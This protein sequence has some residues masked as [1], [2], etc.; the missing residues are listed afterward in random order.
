MNNTAIQVEGLSKKYY[1]GG[2]QLPYQTIRERLT[3]AITALTKPLANKKN[4]LPFWA[5][6]D[7][8][9]D[10]NY[11]ETVG[12][13]GRNGAGKST[14]LKLL[15]RITRPTTGRAK[16]YG[17]VGSLLEVGTGF[18]NE[19]TGRE[20]VYLNGAILGMKK[21]EIE[22]KFDE[23]VNFAEIE[24]FLDTP[25]KHY[26]SGMYMRLAFAVAAHLDPEILLVDEVLAV[27]DAS[28]QKKCLGK[29]KDVS[30]G[31]RT[32]LFVSH[33]HQAVRRLCEKSIWLENGYL[34][35]IGA[36]NEVLDAY[37][38]T[39]NTGV[40]AEDDTPDRLT[41]DPTNP[42][43]FLRLA[44][45]DSTGTPT[46]LLYAEE[47]YFIEIEYEFT[48]A[49][50]NVR[51]AALFRT[52]QDIDAFLT[53]DCDVSLVKGQKR[54][55]GRYLTRCEIPAHLLSQGRYRI[56]VWG[57]VT[58]VRQLRRRDDALIVDVQYT[59]GWIMQEN[60]TTAVNPL[61]VWDTKHLDG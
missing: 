9:F 25:V 36:T 44:V 24:K 48:Y 10:I 21:T 17:R 54:S 38:H 29:M 32:V 49:I 55:P 56:T 20:N 23:I 14:L 27:G 26:S 8:S 1:L 4:N 46:S 60:R 30:S 2:S 53:T 5:L 37:L 19:L 41:Q 58:H 51:I 3:T 42:L 57:A 52:A 28:F 43:R 16:I 33:N 15:S 39:V 45:C 35:Q 40:K 11:G 47:T 50:D 59:K 61:L 22:R 18:H 6:Q 7:V 12:I 34:K 31:G 13:V